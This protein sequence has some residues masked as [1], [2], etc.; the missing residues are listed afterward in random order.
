VPNISLVTSPGPHGELALALDAIVLDVGLAGLAIESA[1]RLAPERHLV[2][3]LVDAQGD[4]ALPSRVVW[5][6]F[7][8][9]VPA[10][11][12]EQRPVYRA[13]V[14]F[15]DLLTPAAQ[16]LV[17]FLER[18]VEPNR[19]TRLFGRFPLTRSQEVRIEAA[20][21]FRCLE[22]DA[23]RV[24]VDA[25]VGVEPAVGQSATLLPRTGG[26]AL[27]ATVAAT[28]RGE[29]LDRWRLTL[30]IGGA[31]PGARAALRGVAFD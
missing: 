9:T 17:A 31:E 18:Q 8:G 30:D 15:A 28:Q 27:T 29:T 23:D 4:L 21:A 16:R 2:V 11:S 1:Y 20:G 14:E 12:G 5:C 25:D 3:R 19:E 24:T 6:F 26:P 13:G 10:A 22:F 7:H